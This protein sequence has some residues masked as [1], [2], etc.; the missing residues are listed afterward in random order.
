MCNM[1]CFNCQKPDCDYEELTEEERKNQNDTEFEIRAERKHGKSKAMWNYQ[2]SEKGKATLKKYNA[3]EKGK[4]RK[5][6]YMQTDKGKAKNAEYCRAYYY[7]QKLK[8]SMEGMQNE[9][10]AV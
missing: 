7:R 1:D 6:R 4:E 3:S 2:H 9:L 8:K 5:K 10:S